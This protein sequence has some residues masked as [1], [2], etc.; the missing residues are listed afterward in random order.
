MKR[1]R[2]SVILIIFLF[3]EIAFS[4][5]TTQRNGIGLFIRGVNSGLITSDGINKSN[6]LLGVD[7]AYIRNFTNWLNISI[8]VGASFTMLEVDDRLLGFH[9]DILLQMGLF[10]DSRITAPYLYL[11]PQFILGRDIGGKLGAFNVSGRGGLGLNLAISSKSLI[12][13]HA[14]YQNDFT[15][16]NKGVVEAGL[17]YV[18]V[19]GGGKSLINN[20]KLSKT[21]TDNDG[22]IDIYDECPT[23]PGV[24]AFKG[25]PDSDNDGIA[26]YDDKCPLLAGTKNTLGCPDKDNDG[27]ADNDD[28]CPDIPGDMRYDGC[29]F[30]DKDKDGVNDELDKC[31]DI[32]GLVRYQGCPDTDGD[33]I[34]DHLDQCVNIAGSPEAK[35]CPDSDGDGIVDS[36]DKCPTVSGTIDNQGCPAANQAALDVLAQTSRSITWGDNETELSAS[37]RN[38]LDKLVAMLKK[39]PKSKLLIMGFADETTPLNQ[40]PDLANARIK[41]VKNYLIT[42]GIEESRLLEGPKAKPI[43]F[44]R[45]ILFEF[46]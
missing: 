34:P 33:G 27:V 12:N 11:G 26:D 17:G 20:S 18:Y 46:K 38:Q 32:K 3:S 9:G 24:V 14:G 15:D 21:D 28:K 8:P 13:I 45:K 10:S 44:T 19:F 29:P 4:Q 2:W 40:Q 43:I 39:N 41:V 16:G 31:P 25:C 37:A 1:L 22:I 6:S 36:K 30:F 35:G 23:T 5:N 42:K 7:L